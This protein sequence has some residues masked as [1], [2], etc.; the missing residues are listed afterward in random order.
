MSTSSES[1]ALSTGAA[2]PAAAAGT[3]NALK[4]KLSS[5]PQAHPPSAETAVEI[6]KGRLV[7]TA[8][9]AG[10]DAP[11]KTKR[12]RKPQADITDV[13]II[14]I[15]EKSGEKGVR[16]LALDPLK[17][18]LKSGPLPPG[19]KVSAWGKIKK[20]EVLDIALKK[21]VSLMTE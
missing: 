8:A 12:Q 9:Y 5:T 6:Q 11:V 20:A 13:S 7:P 2:V 18:W 4:R 14:A 17:K 15:F 1:T 16:K 21:L 3:T 10:D 19:I